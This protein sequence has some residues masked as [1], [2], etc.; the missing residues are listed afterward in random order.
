MQLLMSLQLFQN[1]KY[2]SK[3]RR[4]RRRGRKS[5]APQ[6]LASKLREKRE[7]GKALSC[8]KALTSLPSHILPPSAPFPLGHQIYFLKPLAKSLSSLSIINQARYPMLPLP[9]P[10]TW[11]PA[12]ACA[13]LAFKHSLSL[14]SV[15][16]CLG[17]LSLLLHLLLPPLSSCHLSHPDSEAPIPP[18]PRV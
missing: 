5:L 1:R 4:K 7:T 3:Q 14:G 2:K 9:P 10:W 17:N 8:S 18:C 15:M 6:S 11:P 16:P 13:H 12:D